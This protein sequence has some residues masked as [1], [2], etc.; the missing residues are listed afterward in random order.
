MEK[1]EILAALEAKLAPLEAQRRRELLLAGV[2]LLLTPFWAYLLL[3]AFQ[4][5]GVRGL[6]TLWTLLVAIP[7]GLALWRLHV[8]RSTLKWKLAKPLAE[9]LGFTYFPSSGLSREDVEASGLL[10]RADRYESEDFLEGQVGPF[11]FRSGDIALY[12]KQRTKNG[13]RYVQ[14]FQGTLYR[15]SLPFAFPQEVRLAPQGAGVQAGGASPALVLGFLA[16]FWGIFVLG[17]TFGEGDKAE[18]PLVVGGFALL[19]LPFLLY[20]LGL[21]KPGV[22]PRERVALESG[23]FEQLFDVYGDQIEARKLLTP[24]VQEA[25]VAFRKALG[26]PFWAAFRGSEAWFLIRGRNRFEPSPLRPLNRETLR[27]YVETWT[28]DLTEAKRLLEAVGLDLEARKRGLLG[29]E[30]AT[31][32]TLW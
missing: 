5:I 13:T 3:K 7:P 27:G 8:L 1:E 9:A 11:A 26:K 14:I 31:P 19:S 29:G 16:L 6:G 2:L 4:A 32:G 20:G 12:Q 28:H 30:G 18:L 22:G 23:E 10:P 15:F 24:R 25:L 21:W 17:V